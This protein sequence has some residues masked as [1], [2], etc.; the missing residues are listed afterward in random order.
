MSFRVL[1]D[2]SLE[3][4]ALLQTRRRQREFLHL[5][6]YVRVEV[7]EQRKRSALIRIFVGH[8]PLILPSLCQADCCFC[9]EGVTAVLNARDDSLGRDEHIDLAAASFRLRSRTERLYISVT[10]LAGRWIERRSQAHLH[11]S[12][13]PRVYG[14]CLVCIRATHG[15]DWHR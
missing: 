5:C 12:L 1:R 11:A 7:D 3:V 14:V 15:Q 8:S 4:A 13:A 2:P 10:D 6:R 9:G